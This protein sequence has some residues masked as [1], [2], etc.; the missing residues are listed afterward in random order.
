MESDTLVEI[1]H[2][3]R[4]VYFGKIGVTV[5]EIVVWGFYLF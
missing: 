2:D 3:I 1:I 5:C 4:Q